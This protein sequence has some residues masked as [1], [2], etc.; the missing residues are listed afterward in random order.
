[1]PHKNGV[2]PTYTHIPIERRGPDC[3]FYQCQRL[4]R[5]KSVLAENNWQTTAAIS[6]D[7]A[8]S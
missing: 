8:K 7:L 3:N 5:G 6:T 4:S 2:L 1:M